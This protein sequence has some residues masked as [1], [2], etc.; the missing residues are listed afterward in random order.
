MS[1]ARNPD[2]AGAPAA[3][4]AAPA[5]DYFLASGLRGTL[6]EYLS[7]GEIRDVHRACRFGAEAHTGQTRRSGEPYIHHPI[8]VARTMAGLR[9]DKVTLIAG[10]LHDVLE[11]THITQQK[12]R[13][14]FGD[15]VARVVEGVSKLQG[16]DFVSV[17]VE[18]AENFQ[19][20]MLAVAMDLRVI[21]VKIADR[22]HNMRTLE[23]MPPH[24]QKAIA[25]ETLEI[26]APLALRL[27]MGDV[28]LEFEDLA[29]RTLHPRRHGA[30]AKG[31][32]ERAGNRLELM[33]KAVARIRFHLHESGVPCQVQGRRK[34]LYSIYRKMKEKNL[35][36]SEVLDIFA[37]R[38]VVDSVEDCYRALGLM[39][40]FY[41]PV[42]GRFKD[43][44]A[45]PKAN[46][47]Q[48][49]HTILFGPQGAL[50]E[51]QIRTR[52]MDEVAQTGVAAYALY[53]IN[54]SRRFAGAVKT[55]EW[56]QSLFNFQRGAGDS[57]EFM[58]HLKADLIPDDIYVFT[59]NG[60]IMA[61]PKK[62]TALDFAFAVHTDLG[63][64]ASGVR[65]NRRLGMLSAVLQSGQTVEIISSENARPNPGWLSFAVTAKAR[66]A[67]RHYLKDIRDDEAVKLGKHLLNEALRNYQ[68]SL[69]EIGK[70]WFD[71]ILGALD[72]PGRD[73]LFRE[74]GLGNQI[75]QL[76]AARLADSDRRA[77]RPVEIARSAVPRGA[78]GLVVTYA[79]CCYPIPGDTVIGIMNPGKGLV[80]H[81][82]GCP[83][84]AAAAR[85]R[86][87]S[88]IPL[89]WT[90]DGA[91]DDEYSAA[92]RAVTHHQRGVLAS[93]AAK[94]AGMG[95]N[96][97]NISFEER[98]TE[99][100]AITFVISVKSRAQLEK[101]M[102]GIVNAVEG[103][104][105]HRIGFREETGASH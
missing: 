61:L 83:N 29:F 94:V 48:S 22:L 73:A 100:A 77:E 98:G 66:S 62:A 59:P 63:L 67:I 20:M 28:R 46:G 82:D 15:E 102:R 30:L 75:P 11:D 68:T 70:D 50:M 104:K 6:E 55:Q 38:L 87:D 31:V 27:G 101:I 53:K 65:I 91:P 51:T 26:Y 47:Y 24:R 49:L 12:L 80:V 7:A 85:K 81:R 58:E 32:R 84:A 89:Q 79:K 54:D 14:E 17:E 10:L 41:K 5:E 19:K 23:H 3:P 18:Q 93:I 52:E 103:T 37:V 72:I 13:A 8:E 16:L 56:L 71:R 36:F 69:G 76:I 95:S 78:R 33:E 43:Y 4:P 105:V 45:I 90:G 88:V 57:L 9:L 21:L 40:N 74:I 86:K 60:E 44:I 34:H 2:I 99:T 97:E 35:P 92:I 42:P 64:S 39:H 96:I 25:R 1:V